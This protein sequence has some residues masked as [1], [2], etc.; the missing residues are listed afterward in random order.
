MGYALFIP[1]GRRTLTL[2]LYSLNFEKLHLEGTVS[3][4]DGKLWS[5]NSKRFSAPVARKE[6][7]KLLKEQKILFSREHSHV[8]EPLMR[9]EKLS[10]QSVE[11]CTPCLNK[12]RVK[13]VKK[14]FYLLYGRKVCRSCAEEELK[15][16]LKFRG[17]STAS[18][19]HFSKLL[20]RFRD[21]DRV[22]KLLQSQSLEE[23]HTLFDKVKAE[24][25]KGIK[26]EELPINR[27]F[28]EILKERNIEELT[29]IQ[30]LAL[31]AGLL[32][33]SSL[34]VASSTASGKTLIAELAGIEAALRGEK[35]LFLVPL[36]ALANQKYEEFKVYSSLGLRV[37]IRVGRSRIVDEDEPLMEDSKLEGS[38]IIVGTYEGIDHLLRSGKK[39]SL[40]KIGVVAVDEVHTLSQEERGI[41]LDGFLSRLRHAFPK[42]RIIALTATVGNP[43]E[44]AEHYSLRL[45]KS[46]SRPIPL[47]RHLVFTKSEEEKLSAILK[48]VKREAAIKSSKGFYGQSLVFTNSRRKASSIA[49]FLS[50]RGV[51]ASEYHA[52]LSYSRRKRI[53]NNFIEQKLNCVVTTSALGAG[54]DFPA[55]Q[56]IFESLTMGNKELGVR[57]FLQMQGRAGRPSYHDRGKVVIL[58]TPGAKTSFSSKESEDE[59]A[60]KLLSGKPED[61]DIPGEEDEE[62]E[63]LLAC[64]VSAGSIREGVRVARDMLFP[65]NIEKALKKLEEQGMIRGEKITQLGRIA[66]RHFL[67]PY[68][69]KVMYS[70]S[71]SPERILSKLFPFTNAYLSRSLASKIQRSYKVAVPLRYFDGLGIIFQEPR[72][73]FMDIV[74][75]VREEFLRCSCEEF[76]YCQHAQEEL[77]RKIIQLRRQGKSIKEL[78]RSLSAYYMETFSGDIFNYLDT[79][80]RKAEGLLEIM[81]LR[82]S[83][84]AEE[85]RRLIKEMMGKITT[86][87]TMLT[88]QP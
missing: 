78:S 19:E 82:R 69:A 2:K 41:E 54:I 61:I 77:S 26:L 43:E 12:G 47:E 55:S 81:K 48:L 4:R 7:L 38:D 62:E 23:S 5:L 64:I 59:I 50:S 30:K 22:S 51:K 13:P 80:V 9:K 68:E 17:F 70:S 66:S 11:L 8:L 75:L 60:V 83:R 31:G 85:V 20:E 39:E 42:A 46:D 35:F 45:V 33:G 86:P 21:F 88:S 16:E 57:D 40:G 49:R 76:P 52:G 37:A 79:I 36:V 74:E 24:V 29:S 28:R 34:L 44:I 15:R 58:A 27:E 72:E 65:V 84:K 18:F 67:K 3:I 10:Y 14:N 32:E 63:Q 6:L 53:E 71:E 1:R 73:E 87:F 56:V 25:E